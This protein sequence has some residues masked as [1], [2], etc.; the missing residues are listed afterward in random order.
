MP[1]ARP[2]PRHT[3]IPRLVTVLSFAACVLHAITSHATEQ[4]IIAPTL[5]GEPAWGDGS[6]CVPL[7]SD[8]AATLS[9][10][11]ENPRDQELGGI[12]V[13]LPASR[14]NPGRV[15]VELRNDVGGRPGE[16]VLGVQ[17]AD[18]P[19]GRQWL[20]LS[21]G[22]VFL[23]AGDRYHLLLRAADG[24]TGKARVCYVWHREGEA[25]AE[26]PWA[27]LQLTG[28]AWPPLTVGSGWLEPVFVLRFTDDS[29]WGQ[30]Y[31][32]IARGRRDA[33]FAG[34]GLEMRLDPGP[35]QL[36]GLSARLR[37]RDPNAVLRYRL[38]SS[39]GENIREG[40][41]SPSEGQALWPTGFAGPIDPPL[42]P[43]SDQFYV[44]VVN[45]PEARTPA[46]GFR[47]YR[48]VTDF[49]YTP[50][51]HA[52]A[53]LAAPG[54]SRDRVARGESSTAE[55]SGTM[56]VFVTTRDQ[57]RC[58][59]GRIDQP[60]ERCDGRAGGACAGNCNP[61]CTCGVDYPR[62]NIAPE[63]QVTVS[64]EATALGA[65][66]HGAVD[67]VVDGVPGNPAHEWATDGQRGEAWI[68]LTWPAPV[69][70]NRVVL[71]DRPSDMDNVTSGSLILPDR[72][73][74]FG[75]IPTDGRSQEI[76]FDTQLVS[77]LTVAIHSATGG[78]AGLA[79]IEVI[80]TNGP[81]RG[82]GDGRGGGGGGTDTGG[83]DGGT[84]GGDGGSGSGG[85]GA[86]GGAGGG[87][88]G[89][90]DPDG[91]AADGGDPD[92]SGR[93]FYIGPKGNDG[94]AGTSRDTPWKTFARV[95]NAEKP[96][97]AG[98]TLVLLDGTYTRDD[99]RALPRIDC[100]ATGNARNGSAGEPITIRR[101]TSGRR[102]CSPT[103]RAGVRDGGVLVVA[104]RGAARAERGQRGPA[105]RAQASRS[106]STRC[107]TSPRRRLLGSH[108]N[109]MQ[110]T[111]VFAV[112]NSEN[113]LLEECEA[114][115]FH[116]HA[117]SIW[118]LPRRH[119]A[120]LLRQLDA[121]R[122]ERLLRP[123]RQPRLRRRGG[124]AVR[125]VRQH[126]RELHQREPGERL[127]DPR[128]QE[129]ARP[130]RDTA[131][132]TTACSAASRSGRGPDAGRLAR[133]RSDRRT[134]TPAATC[135]EISSPRP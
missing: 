67:G 10:R 99:D 61:D 75:P 27:A 69:K 106:A 9:F 36:T 122:D 20:F 78:A 15:Y 119:A 26:H 37:Q 81:I 91:G 102:H 116:R 58:G 17:E 133:G 105:A 65:R 83:G 56:S 77:S 66:A 22:Q 73:I 82:G 131:G 85:G 60:S 90:G 38:M 110:N 30:P 97:V 71:H 44:L 34:R 124:L 92:A 100:T 70:I 112:E 54:T 46:Q 129:P 130:V 94:S 64:T 87:G 12:F 39:R 74:P 33:I 109:R 50:V 51:S 59:N 107:A 43:N 5:S 49:P 42:E 117:F 113:V 111:H 16:D 76:A 8:P 127:P 123:H 1:R 98:D 135:S 47:H 104:G 4:G 96:L 32:A 40:V 103:A 28:E 86:G 80:R 24:S 120:T 79:E 128:H 93:V 118:Q 2:R 3:G 89:G 31:W 132:A 23:T 63:A 84:G 6:K 53:A 7:P 114:Y 18:L 62:R 11:F 13:R 25:P 48:P 29:V 134:T 14:R 52:P 72:E 21:V 101:R 19:P 108:N 35:V 88:T 68:Q 57:P 121:L 126:H 45:A 41:L 115:F 95:F 55:S 125:H